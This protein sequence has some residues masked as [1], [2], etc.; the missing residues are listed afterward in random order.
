MP[1]GSRRP[2]AKL[3]ELIALLPEVFAVRVPVSLLFKVTKV[4]RMARA[5]EDIVTERGYGAQP[6]PP[7]TG[8]ADEERTVFCFPPV[9]GHGLV[10][11][12]L[13][14]CLPEYAL[15]AFNC[16]E[17]E[18]DVEHYA[19]LT[20]SLRADGP[21]TRFGYSLGGNLA[22]EGAK[23]LERRG[24]EV[25]DVVITDSYRIS[26][27]F[28]FGDHHLAAFEHGL[29]GHLHRHTG[30]DLVARHTLEQ[31]REFIAF[32][33]RSP[34]L[35]TVRARISV[36]SDQEEVPLY[37]ADRPGSRPGASTTHATMLPGFGSHAGMLDEEFVA[38]NA[39]PTRRVLTGGDDRVLV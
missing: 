10:Y 26:E 39:E 24:R 13:A 5:L 33:S 14:A 11:R 20:E 32:C 3:I 35:G 25:A 27:S 30:S 18:G 2:S 1:C 8:E 38:R 23:G 17:G 34:G 16:V 36:V 12:Q 9:G 22:F 28:E 7:F 4:Q 21:C 37:A 6:Y 19:D 31:V 29:S 15:V